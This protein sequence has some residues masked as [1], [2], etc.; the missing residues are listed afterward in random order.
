MLG[1]EADALDATQDALVAA[2]RSLGRFDGRSSFGT[3][4]FRIATNTCI[5][6]L[7][8]RRRRPVTGLSADVADIADEISFDAPGLFVAPSRPDLSTADA[9]VQ[10]ED[11][12]AGSRPSN[13]GI[14][15]RAGGFS[16]R[17][18][19]AGGAR[20]AGGA[21]GAGGAR[22][23]GWRPG[24]SDHADPADVASARVDIDAALAVLPLE[25][26]TAV[27]L[28][29]VCDLAYDE[30]AAILGVPVGTVRSR[31]ARARSA[32]AATWSVAQSGRDAAAEG[33]GRGDTGNELVPP[34]VK[35]QQSGMPEPSAIADRARDGRAVRRRKRLG[36]PIAERS[37]VNQE[38]ER[39]Q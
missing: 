16:A 38:E 4:L 29:D 32:L 26:R 39:T 5:D 22:G 23:G 25:F 37:Q 8:R 19:S 24:R 2:I 6:E 30:I 9:P 1:N 27:V 31:I 15:N 36:E 33:A 3:W 10:H 12:I 20:G 7:R 34:D 28:R 13:E 17:G 35:A 11:A 14:G 18:M 21:G